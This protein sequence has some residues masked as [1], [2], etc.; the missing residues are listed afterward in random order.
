MRIGPFVLAASVFVLPSLAMAQDNAG[1]PRAKSSVLLPAQTVAWR[2]YV[3]VPDGP[4][5]PPMSVQADCYVG[6]RPCG[7]LRPVCFLHRVGRMLDCLIPCNL[8][9][10]SGCGS[11]GCILGGKLGCNVCCGGSSCAAPSCSSCA[12]SCVHPCGSVF[13][14]CCQPSCSAPTCGA[15]TCGAPSCS[16][17]TGGHCHGCSST[18]PAT[19]VP[20]LS[21]PFQDDPL[22]PKPTAH[23]ATEVRRIPAHSAR[24]V[25]ARSA[26]AQP[27][28]TAAP[29]A[30]TSPYKI[31]SAPQAST[32]RTS[33]QAISTPATSVRK[34]SEQSVLRRASAEQTYNEP[35]TLK[36]DRQRTQPIVRSQSPEAD[37]AYEIPANPL[38]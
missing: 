28:V 18:V 33:R 35:A 15:P 17:T 22:P 8:C 29:P 13:D 37:A 14:S 1:E 23:P 24:P 32:P 7:P 6:S 36:V 5:G 3:T 20:A 34:S 26:T 9:C 2:N 27:R 11:H 16:C 21:D 25:S 38:R 4:C 12:S 30:R 31:V 19:K 10:K